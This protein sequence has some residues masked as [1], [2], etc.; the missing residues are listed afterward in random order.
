MK[1]GLA[2]LRSSLTMAVP[3]RSPRRRRG[4]LARR[5]A[6]GATR[7]G[8]WKACSSRPSG[9]APKRSAS[10]MQRFEPAGVTVLTGVPRARGFL[11]DGYGV[12]FDVEIPDMNQSVI[13][14]MMNVQRDRQVGNALDSLRAALDT[15]PTVRTGSRRRWRS[16]R[17]PRPSAPPCRHA[18]PRDSPLRRPDRSAP[19]APRCPIPTASIPN[20]VKSALVE[21]MLG[22]SMQ[23]DLGPD[24]WLT[25]AARASEGPM[26]QP[27]CPTSSRSCCA[28]RAATCRRITPTQPSGRRF[29]S[30]SRS[31]P[32]CS[33]LQSPHVGIRFGLRA[34]AWRGSLATVLLS[35]ALAAAGSCREAVDFKQTLQVTDVSGGWFDAGIV[36]G[37]NK[38][39]PSVSF[40]IRKPA[41]VSLRSLSLNVHLQEDCRSLEARTGR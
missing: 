27:A 38:L 34:A 18:V 3:R 30:G 29:G 1:K 28:S 4:A 36:D 13:W 40:R 10:E 21:A 2:D 17:S 33:D 37:K 11:L 7:S 15:L 39:V 12:F 8:S 41:D 19:P 22:Y 25:V 26:P 14:S 5:A 6:R 35:L 23:M 31:K 9:S 16:S 32:G 20:A 24:E